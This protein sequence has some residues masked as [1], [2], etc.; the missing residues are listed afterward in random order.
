MHLG[1]IAI[2]L[3]D[4]PGQTMREAAK[5]PRGWWLP[6]LLLV[7]GLATYAVV[8]A[9]AQVS[10]ANERSA[11]FIERLTE[12]MSEQQAQMVR[13]SSRP[14]DRPTYLLSAIGGGLAAMAAGW[15]ARGALVHFGSIA[16]GGV[17]TWGSAFACSLWSMV[18]YFV[19]DLLMTALFVIQG[20]LT[21]QMGLSF[22]VS[23]GDWLRDSRSIPVALLSTIDP[24][25]VWHLVL[26]ALA[27]TAATRLG[28]GR[29]AF[30]AIVVWAVLTA[31]KL[32][33]VA[34]N[35]AIIG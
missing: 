15:I 30:L 35:A 10:L 33:P 1:A 12:A 8:T 17:S 14:L 11:Q 31:V 6:A 24:F 26:L 4:R 25:M 23:S 28:R 29:A 9:D 13:E 16:V 18:P 21:E 19:R 20:R 27:I 2:A 22:L 34:I 7:I 5:R 32:V 3:I